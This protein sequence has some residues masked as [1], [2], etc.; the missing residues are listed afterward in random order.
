MRLRVDWGSPRQ[1]LGEKFGYIIQDY[2]SRLKKLFCFF[3]LSLR[4]RM[5][6]WEVERGAFGVDVSSATPSLPLTQVQ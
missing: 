5:A 2:L 6:T 4:K 3:L 1:Q